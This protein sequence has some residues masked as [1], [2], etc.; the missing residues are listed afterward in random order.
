MWD[1][2]KSLSTAGVGYS[3]MGTGTTSN[4]SIPLS[5]PVCC[6][7]ALTASLAG[8]I[9]AHHIKSVGIV[10]VSIPSGEAGVKLDESLLKKHHVKIT[11]TTYHANGAPDLTG[12]VQQ[13]MAG[14]PAALLLNDGPQDDVREIPLLRQN[15]YA[16]KIFVTYSMENIGLLKS[17]GASASGL[18]VET[19]AA[20]PT[21]F[22]ES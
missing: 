11:S 9:I 1:A 18:Y 6:G 4:T 12:V 22:D 2:A 10:G 21:R 16:G 17:L 19:A 5:Y 15:G 20:L 8:Y 14:H 3:S 13:A 7:S